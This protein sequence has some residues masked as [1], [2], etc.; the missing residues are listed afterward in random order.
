MSETNRERLSITEEA[1]EL[2]AE[3]P[4]YVVAYSERLGGA[5]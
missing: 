5:S 1:H 4:V 3:T 2:T